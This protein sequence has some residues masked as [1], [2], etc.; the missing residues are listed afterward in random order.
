MHPNQI[1]GRGND[2][3]KNTHTQSTV[4]ECALSYFQRK[5][6]YKYLLLL[7]SFLVEKLHISFQLNPKS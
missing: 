4:T 5:A 1:I 2:Y 3:L 6:L 7:L